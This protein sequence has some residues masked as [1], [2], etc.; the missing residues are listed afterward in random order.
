MR[1]RT[2][3]NASLVAVI[4]AGIGGCGK[5]NET[6]ATAPAAPPATGSA[7][8][9]APAGPGGALADA[10][11]LAKKNGCLACHAVE[12]RVVGPG[13]REVAV[14]YKGEAGAEARL[15][16]KVKQGGSGVWGQI[17]MPPNPNLSDA[18][19]KKLVAWI[20]AQ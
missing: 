11:E 2:V 7:P 18:D 9:A 19:A 15:I 16:A 17:P 14:R 8:S 6:A 5:K 3:V 12:K 10:S 1:F 4:A 13:Y 20:L